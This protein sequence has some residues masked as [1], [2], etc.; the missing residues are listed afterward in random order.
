MT[1]SIILKP[2]PHQAKSATRIQALDCLR[3]VACMCVVA[4]HT[5][6]KTIPWDVGLYG[7]S[8]FCVLSGFLITSLI[9]SEEQRSSKFDVI[10]FLQRRAFRILPMYFLVVGACSAMVKFG[11]ILCHR[12]EQRLQILSEFPYWVTL[13]HNFNSDHFLSHLWSISIE[14]QFYCGLPIILICFKGCAA[15]M[16]I[17]AC[18]AV[19]MSSAKTCNIAFFALI[20]GAYLALYVSTLSPLR[21]K[22]PII[23]LVSISSALLAAS[24][25]F[26]LPP[27]GPFAV[28]SFVILI[29]LAS[30][31]AKHLRVLEP[32]AYVGKISYGL[33]LV[34][35]PVGLLAA[36]VMTEFGLQNNQL[37][38]FLL[39]ATLSI[40]V[41]A[42]SW[43]ILEKRIIR[44]GHLY[45][46]K[47]RT[48]IAVALI[49]P[50]LL[51]I[52]LTMLIA[53]CIKSGANPLSDF[54]IFGMF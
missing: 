17:L 54:R 23:L 14:E 52:G 4:W 35:L 19:I 41:A 25:G 33:Y 1:T 11:I 47:N 9:I 2:T 8:L 12:D 6:G 24:L 21:P 3:A 5:F 37:C 20:S 30:S 18:L 45:L 48:G 40:I 10:G 16:T 26:G 15:R 34:H 50:T 49:S 22:I 46:G 7:V 44:C 38:M 43:E 36:F 27:F 28:V 53:N 31:R 29:W 42:M 51:I 32:I 39:T 13:S